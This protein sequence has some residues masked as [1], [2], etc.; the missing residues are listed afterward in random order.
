MRKSAPYLCN[1]VIDLEFTP[2][3]TKACAGG[4]RNE[5]V[6]VGAVKLAPDGSI[7]AEF[8]HI[9]RPTI[10]RGV[11]GRVHKLTGIGDE[12][13][14]CARPLPEVLEALSAWIGPGRVRMVTWSGHD[15]KQIK[16]ECEAKGIDVQLPNRWLDIQSLYPRLVGLPHRRKVALGEA[17]DWCG[18]PNNKKE[19]HRALYDAKMTARIFAMMAAGEFSAHKERMR[20]VIATPE[21]KAPCASTIADRCSGLAAL[22]AG[23]V[24]SEAASAA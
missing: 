12:D 19:A 23:L 11:S 20:T 5:I 24:A 17:A 9:V 14:L 13:V 6:E 18:I 3:P 4:L 7:V 15:L 1:V 22:L 8:S 2:V 16:S 10:G 21:E